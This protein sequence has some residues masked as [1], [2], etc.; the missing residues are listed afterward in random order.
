MHRPS[1]KGMEYFEDLSCSGIANRTAIPIKEVIRVTRETAEFGTTTLDS[2]GSAM[3]KKKKNASLLRSKDRTPP[4]NETSN[5]IG[6]RSLRVEITRIKCYERNPRRSK[7]PEYGRIKASILMSGMD[8]PLIITRRP[9]EKH[10][11]VQ[12]GGNTRLQILKELFEV[13]CEERFFRIDCLFVEWDRESSVLLAHL[14]ENELRGN[15]TFID[16]A[17]AVFDDSQPACGC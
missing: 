4:D 16:K 8:Q 14:R 7:N 15:L 5:S 11:I 17:R 6:R 13:T 12:A 3:T 2:R 10:Y 9:G 1:V